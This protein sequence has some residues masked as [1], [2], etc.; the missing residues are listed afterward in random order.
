MVRVISAATRRKRNHVGILPPHNNL[1]VLV[2]NSNYYVSFPT[3]L[4][5]LI[6]AEI[7]KYPSV[8]QADSYEDGF[9]KVYK[10]SQKLLAYLIKDLKKIGQSSGLPE[11]S[12]IGSQFE[13][14][15]R[16][17]ARD[18]LHLL[19]RRNLIQQTYA[20]SPIRGQPPAFFAF[21]GGVEAA[22]LV[23]H[24]V[25]NVF[26]GLQKSVQSVQAARALAIKF[27]EFLNNFENFLSSKHIESEEITNVISVF[28]EKTK[29]LKRFGLK[30][31]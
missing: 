18:D 12:S 17:L 2:G 27:E 11:I 22:Q 1:P 14:V 23:L 3:L 10:E 30:V 8:E 19:T 29:E 15:V 13:R 31:A 24:K 25:S 21:H 16:S 20:T 6:E 9:R 26:V 7:L 4:D 5:I 28:R